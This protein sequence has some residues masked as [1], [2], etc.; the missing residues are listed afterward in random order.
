MSS[1]ERKIN[2]DDYFGLQPGQ[3]VQNLDSGNRVVETRVVQPENVS[4]S[5]TG[6][7]PGTQTGITGSNIVY[8]TNNRGQP[9]NVTFQNVTGG[10]NVQGGQYTQGG[11]Y[12]TTSTTPTR[13]IVQGGNQNE[14]F[15]TGQG[16]NQGNTEYFTTGQQVISQGPKRVEII[17]S[18]TGFNPVVQT[19]ET[20]VIQA[21][22]QVTKTITTVEQPKTIVYT[23]VVNQPKYET[24]TTTT[25]QRKPLIEETHAY[26]S[27]VDYN[28]YDGDVEDLHTEVPQSSGPATCGLMSGILGLL[29]GLT[30]VGL[31]AAIWHRTG[32]SCFSAVPLSHLIM[33]VLAVVV[34]LFCI[35]VLFLARKAISNHGDLNHLLIAIALIAALI[36]FAY[37]LASGVYIYMFRPFHYS[38]L[39]TQKC[40]DGKQWNETFSQETTFEEGW[41]T[42]RRVLWWAAFFSLV[43]AVVFLIVAISLWLLT[44]FPVQV[45][46]IVLGAA[47]L[48]GFILACF[49]ITY[50]IQARNLFGNSLALKDFNFSYLTTLIVLFAIGGVLLFLNAIWN[51]F[52][53]RSG[54]FIFGTVL[55]V[56][57]FIFVCFL[58]L[59]L[60]SFRATQFDNLQKASNGTCRDLIS[61]YNSSC[62]SNLC[63]SKY[64]AAGATCSKDFMAVQWE[65]NNKEG[66]INP[67]CCNAFASALLC[68]LYYAGIMGLLFLAAVIVAI[69][70]NYYLS[71][72][73]EYLEFSDK[74][75]GIYELLFVIGI[76][77]A[78]IGFGFYW[79]FGLQGALDS[80]TCAQN[81]NNPVIHRDSFGN[82]ESYSDPNFQSVNLNK[83]YKGNVPQSAYLQGAIRNTDPA[84]PIT[85]TSTPVALHTANN[86]A[87]LNGNE[88]ACALGANCGWRLGVL[89][90]NGKILSSAG[91]NLVGT[92]NGRSIYF[93]D[94][95]SNSDFL[96]LKGS[97]AD[98]NAAL[99]ELKV[100]AIDITKP[101]KLWVN[102]EQLDL[103][104]LS[105]QGLKTGEA[106]AG[107]ALLPNGSVFNGGLLYTEKDLGSNSACFASNTC[108]SN[109]TCGDPAGSLATCKLGYTF[110][111]SNGFI[112]VEAPLIVKDVNGNDIQYSGNGL[113]SNSYFVHQATQ[114]SILNPK[115]DSGLL[116][117]QIPKPVS[118]AANAVINLNDNANQYLPFSKYFII[119][120]DSS[121]PF[122][123][124]PIN[125]ITK[126]GKGCVG[127]ADVASCWANQS[128]QFGTVQVRAFDPEKGAAIAGV[129]VKL[130]SGLDGIRALTSNT[131]DSN[132][133]ATF[134]N[135]AFDYYTA[136]FDGSTNYLPSRAILSVQDKN[137]QLFNLNLRQRSSANTILQ[138]YVSNNNV[139]QD[140]NLN[141]V[142]NKGYGCD[143]TPYTKYCGYASHLN[144]VAN[145]QQGFENIQ[146]HNFTVANY[147]GYLQTNPAS[148]ATCGA[149][150]L[151]NTP[152]YAEGAV[153]SPRSLSFKWNEV[154]KA[155]AVVSKYQSLYCF[156]GWGLNTLRYF[157]SVGNKKPSATDC[158][159]L[160]PD[161]S[162][163][164]LKKLEEL[165]K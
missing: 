93:N 124:E 139:D 1:D 135:V 160:W 50:L 48:A 158:A 122:R 156:N 44:K 136:Q 79:G 157:P 149:S 57:V 128:V 84:V 99:S 43:L 141:I 36:F 100:N 16:Y 145:N 38:D 92:P 12:V 96:L 95:N 133:V 101:T 18:S 74:G 30:L 3:I 32:S 29:A 33:A 162:D 7:I 8:G 39:S 53:K 11:Q 76:I 15:L 126:S 27:P 82:I 42:D 147:L 62:F 34:L 163:W 165:N 56:F 35:I 86:V 68:P 49:G 20:K 120:A 77:L 111:S 114:Y 85:L 17:E 78:V 123:F 105:S 106:P 26:A 151:V 87:T 37:F 41:G 69:A 130:M 60:R 117:F 10:Q 127:A 54:H 72:T 9:S 70:A 119:P 14:F 125:L 155:Q 65:N 134:N 22:T 129:P 61:N 58:G 23:N 97:Q 81:V 63:G 113:T 4:Y 108:Q 25:E 143:V 73:S 71:D 98:V 24:Y 131:T 55:I 148:A 140:F 45:A 107:V 89:A 64:L 67:C 90:T 152:Y 104:S 153:A 116:T 31:M 115:I 94:E 118:G 21:P 150:D 28:F 102:G 83:V 46:R 75:F 146:I 2:A 51:L 159:S 110:H 103:S 144:D 132:G 47:C 142:N 138:Q 40:G 52:K 137:P 80:Q 112:D 154:R 109:L 66:Y 161:S 6:N 121:S 13:T 88:S 164:S 5:Y 19:I 91:S 59:M